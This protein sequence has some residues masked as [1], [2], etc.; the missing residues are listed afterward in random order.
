MP[1]VPDVQRLAR[2]DGRY[3]PE[4]FHLVAAGLRQ[5]LV[6]TGKVG[7]DGDDR[8]L[9]AQELLQGVVD[10]AAERY[11]LLADLVCARWNVRSAQDVGNITFVLV[12]HGIFTKQPDDRLEDFAAAGD[13]TRVLR[14]R[15]QERLIARGMAERN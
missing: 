6:L 13:L 2:Q 3:H 5:A 8:H 12:E 15:A 11:G 14:A 1:R 10:L 9:T 7:R 4:A